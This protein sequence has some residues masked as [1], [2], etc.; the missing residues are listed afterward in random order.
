LTNADKQNDIIGQLN[1]IGKGLRSNNLGKQM[2]KIFPEGFVFINALYGLSWCELAISDSTKDKK[3]IEKAISEALFAYNEINS[4]KAKAIFD[5]NLIPENGIYYLGWNN[6]LLSKILQIDTTFVDF[7]QYKNTFIDQCQT[8]NK[9]LNQSKSPYL[10]SYNNQTWPADMFVAMASI[11]NHDRIFIPKYENEINDWIKKVQNRLDPITKMV[12]HQVD[13]RTGARLE[14]VR[15]SSISLIIRLLSEIDPSFAKEQY[16][17]Y[18]ANFVTT[19]F[20][21]PSISEY[22][23]GQGGKADIDS[24]PVVFGVGFSGTIVSI[25][26]FAKLGDLALAQQQYQTI[27]AFGFGYTSKNEKKYLF[28]LMPIADAFIA[29]GR[30]TE[31]NC[32]NSVEQSSITWRVKFHVISMIVLTILWL[33]LYPERIFAKLK[34]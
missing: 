14:G 16:K 28:G 11:K 2:Q 4:D 17:L 21:L 29:W 20:G 22:P 1:F 27:N 33:F 26:T 31:L 3:L 30:A 13:S 10:Q 6:Y 9:A 25:G 34:N 7:G 18:K 32:K 5:S 23:K 24:G 8:I 12:S 19:T 15:G